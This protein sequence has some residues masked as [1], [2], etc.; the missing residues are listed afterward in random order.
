MEILD[1]LKQ[2]VITEIDKNKDELITLSTQIHDNPELSLQEFKAAEWLTEYLSKNGFNIE[3]N[4]ADLPTAFRAT[5]NGN[6]ERPIIGLLAEYDA[7]PKIGHG[8]GHNIMAVAGPGAAVAVK[9]V[10]KDIP[11]IIQVIGTPAEESGGEN[12]DGKKGGLR[13]PFSRNDC[14]SRNKNRSIL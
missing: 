2:Q 7:L 6:D 5:F 13:S 14:A 8:C 12:H 1:K 11:G 9:N 3:K 10:V 4:I